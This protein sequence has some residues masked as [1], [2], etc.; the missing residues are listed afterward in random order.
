MWKRFKSSARRETI[1]LQ[2][3]KQTESAL[4]YAV[5]MQGNLKGVKNIQ[6][7]PGWAR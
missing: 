3:K 6:N 1:F 7:I 5:I 4:D 2:K